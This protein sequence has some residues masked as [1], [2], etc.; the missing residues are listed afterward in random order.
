M[1]VCVGGVWQG[2]CWGVA[3]QTMWCLLETNILHNL[4][5]GL[6]REKAGARTG[7]GNIPVA[8]CVTTN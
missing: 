4:I 5:R 7:T 3:G 6:L 8:F 2:G 1:C